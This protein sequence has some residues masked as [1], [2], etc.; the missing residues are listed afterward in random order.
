M[1][2]VGNKRGKSINNTHIEFIYIAS[3]ERQLFSPKCVFGRE[4]RN[5]KII[6]RD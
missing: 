5:K 3:S 2:V 6:S 4:A 1:L